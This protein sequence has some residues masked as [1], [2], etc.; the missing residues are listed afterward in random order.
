[1]ESELREKEGGY[2]LE[3]LANPP[4]SLLCLICLSVARSP[5]QHAMCGRLFC[6][7]CLDNYQTKGHKMCPNCKEENPQYFPDIKSESTQLKKPSPQTL[8]S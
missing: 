7:S 8:R 2:D 1:M 6:K 4:D 3:F 5:W